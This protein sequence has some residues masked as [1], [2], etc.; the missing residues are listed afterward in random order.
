MRFR[1]AGGTG[2][3]AV[4]L[5]LTTRTYGVR[6]IL[7]EYSSQLGVWGLVAAGRS[8]LERH[9]SA[10]RERRGQTTLLEDPQ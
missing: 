9:L 8:L 10:A 2:G 6:L 3:I 7:T 5:E 4:Q 1:C